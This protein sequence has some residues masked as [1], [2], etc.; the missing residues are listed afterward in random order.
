MKHIINKL[1]SLRSVDN[2]RESFKTRHVKYGGYAALITL[3]V[4]IGLLLLNLL[5]GQ[6]PMA[7]IDLTWNRIFSLSEQTRQVLDQLD[8]PIQIYGLWRPGEEN[9]QVLDVLNLYTA[10]SRH[11]S[12]EVLD[13]DRNPGFV[14]R[15]DR[16]R[17][18]IPRGS[19]IVEGPLGVRIIYP[20]EMSDSFQQQGGRVVT[21][22]S[23]E[24]RITSA[25]NFAGTGYTPVL[26]ELIGHDQTG[27]LGLGMFEVL[28]RENYELRNLNLMVADIPEDASAIILYAP[29]RD[30]SPIEVE[31]LLDY[32]DNGGRFFVAV[33][34]FIRDLTNLNNLLA[35]Y[36]INYDYGIVYE[37]DPNY[38]GIIDRVTFK[39][40]DVLDHEITRNLM[41]KERT[42]VVL[43][44]AMPISQLETRRREIQIDPL[45]LTS[46]NS[47]LRMDIEQASQER[48][49]EDIPGPFHL[50][51]ALTDPYWIDP[52]NPVPQ[53]RIVAIGCANLLG[54]ANLYNFEANLD[55]FLN[56][57]NWL[58]ERDET[59][60]VRSRSLIQ[61]PMRLTAMHVIIFGALF[62]VVIPLAFF[63]SGF[64]VWIKRRHL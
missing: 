40:P 43:A 14:M 20:A 34:Y 18:G 46:F 26:Y 63:I 47:F 15:Y 51:V 21:G 2:F 58:N 7:Q 41:V 54:I 22:I 52:N 16:D 61:L 45:M 56:S 29:R 53:A 36:G 17:R 64:V 49:A 24:R 12:L 10:R 42:P 3:A 55:I 25:I 11:V 30:L 8:S 32:L 27:L 57:L 28:E 50:G 19:V 23:A 33:N 5:M 48:L 31:K 6:F 1:R 39:I 9:P 13:P 44:S 60:T 38:S 62:I 37:R 35:S 4:I 59:V